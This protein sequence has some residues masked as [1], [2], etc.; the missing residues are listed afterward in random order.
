MTMRLHNQKGITLVEL[1]AVLVL[2]SVVIAATMQFFSV[3]LQSMNHQKTRVE[4]QREATTMLTA[5]QKQLY[6]AKMVTISGSNPK[7]LTICQANDASVSFSVID[8]QLYLE[9]QLIGR[10]LHTW[11]LQTPE[12]NVLEVQLDLTSPNGRYDVTFEE[13]TMFRLRNYEEG[14]ICPPNES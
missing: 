13:T 14:T 5:L 4:L 3:N 12:A 10:N 7:T 11:D 9:D 6:G 2:T 8:Q 1:L